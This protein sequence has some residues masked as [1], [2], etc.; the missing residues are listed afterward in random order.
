[1]T[2]ILRN[3]SLK[4]RQSDQKWRFFVKKCY[5]FWL[6]SRQFA[7]VLDYFSPNLLKSMLFLCQ[8][9][10]FGIFWNFFGYF[11]EYNMAAL[12]GAPDI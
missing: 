5:K 6:L 10:D 9:S 8:N 4:N 11:W 7:K 12:L 1:M 2:K 3:I